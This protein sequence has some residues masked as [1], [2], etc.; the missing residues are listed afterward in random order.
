MTAPS[1]PPIRCRDLSVGYD[2]VPVLENLS[3]TVEE[4]TTVAIVGRSGCG[5]STLL[6]TLAGILEPLGGE[7]TVLGTT[8]PQ[9][10]PRGTL[11]YI[12]QSLGLVM[13]GTVLQNVLHGTLSDLGT[14]RS[15][16][17]RFPRDAEQEARAAIED[18]GLAGTEQSR[19]TEL[20]GGQRRRVAI[21]RAFVQRPRVLLADEMLS[22]LDEETA[23]SIVNCLCEL[24]E[25][26][27]MAVVVVEH[28]RDIARAMSDQVLHLENG[29]I[30]ER[31]EPTST[32]HPDTQQNDV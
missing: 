11:G 24:Q 22:E 32:N 4:A 15:F 14:V 16:L 23:R 12:P 26:T 9:T 6:K 2:G 3:V 28:N 19:V 5:K 8:F 31:I 7:A 10:P 1:P 21:A 18:V 25:G 20:S 17:G 30:Q 13:R 29:G 27:G